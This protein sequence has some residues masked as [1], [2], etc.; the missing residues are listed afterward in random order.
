MIAQL[1]SNDSPG[2]VP[3]Y[4]NAIEQAESKIEIDILKNAD[5]RNK[6]PSTAMPLRPGYNTQGKSILLFANYM[7]LAI[8][9]GLEFFRYAID[10]GPASDQKVPSVKR[11]K[12]LVQL[13]LEEHFPNER[14]HVA[15]DSRTNL[16]SAKKLDKIKNFPRPE[17]TKQ[18]R[19]FL[20]LA[21]HYRKFIPKFSETAGPLF[22]LT[23]K[24]GFS[25]NEAAQVAF[26]R[27]RVALH[28]GATL[29][30]PDFDAPFIVDC[31]ASVSG[32]R[33]DKGIFYRPPRQC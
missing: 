5:A 6:W 21:G 8:E 15:T 19:S 32:I 28:Q 22:E 13:L 17:D 23:T 7:N 26:D 10:I 20:G 25:W 2:T 1:T 9:Q 16:I 27:L 29:Q 14:G 30:H 31:D 12:R 18:V 4:E 24:K 3:A 11:C 33:K